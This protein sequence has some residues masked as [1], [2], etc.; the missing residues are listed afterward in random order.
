MK[1]DSEVQI[2]FSIAAILV[3]LNE[4]N[5]RTNSNNRG[6]HTILILLGFNTLQSDHVSLF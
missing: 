3:S 5:I 4:Y 1:E 6:G 2:R